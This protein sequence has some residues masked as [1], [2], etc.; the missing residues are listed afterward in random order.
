MTRMLIV[1]AIL[2]GAAGA[3]FREPDIPAAG[4]TTNVEATE[5]PGVVSS[6]GAAPRDLPHDS[7]ALRLTRLIEDGM[8]RAEAVL[9]VQLEV[10]EHRC[11]PQA[12]HPVRDR[13]HCD[14]LRIQMRAAAT[15]D[16][17]VT[18]SLTLL[19]LMTDDAPLTDPDE[20]AI[21]IEVSTS[22]RTAG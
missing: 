5:S 8:P 7:P 4:S 2:A 10:Y 16:Q 12:P 15:T 22:G 9:A 1:I 17:Q 20:P 19:T 3:L 14:M 21:R 6:T 18:K 11:A 13:G